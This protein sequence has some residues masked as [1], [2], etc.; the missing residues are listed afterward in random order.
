MSTVKACHCLQMAECQLHQ[1]SSGK[2]TGFSRSIAHSNWSEAAHLDSIKTVKLFSRKP[3]SAVCRVSSAGRVGGCI[4]T[5]SQLWYM[6]SNQPRCT[7]IWSCGAC[8]TKVWTASACVTAWL[9]VSTRTA[10]P[11]AEAMVPN[12]NRSTRQHSLK[13]MP[14]ILNAQIH[15]LDEG[16]LSDDWTLAGALWRC[17]LLRRSNVSAAQLELLV[18]YVRKQLPHLTAQSSDMVLRQGEVTFLPLHGTQHDPEWALKRI[19][20]A[21]YSHPMMRMMVDSILWMLI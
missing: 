11:R 5:W 21:P 17:V 16:L 14:G 13:Q 9:R 18:Q 7:S 3:L 12:S 19:N 8:A 20:Y 10:E 2:A 6:V 4:E 1:R 15:G